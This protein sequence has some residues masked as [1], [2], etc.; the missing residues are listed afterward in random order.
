MPL[1]LLLS[2]S[3]NSLYAPPVQ[4]SKEKARSLYHTPDN[5]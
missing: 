4:S 2:L 3:L 1:L 5:L